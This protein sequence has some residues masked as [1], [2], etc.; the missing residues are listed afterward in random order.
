MTIFFSFQTRVLV[1]HSVRFLPYM[2]QIIV[3]QDGEVSEVCTNCYCC[4][5]IS[6]ALPAVI[7]KLSIPTEQ[8]YDI[9]VVIGSLSTDVFEPRTSTGSRDFPSLIRI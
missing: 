1:T 4:R 6:Y 3:I 8:K 7:T 5:D 9:L 2:D